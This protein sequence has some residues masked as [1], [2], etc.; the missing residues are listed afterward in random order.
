MLYLN[1]DLCLIPPAIL[2]K[3]S[4]ATNHETA[5]DNLQPAMPSSQEI[6]E[7][8]NDS[9]LD[10][11][12]YNLRIDDLAMHYGL[13]DGTAR[14][15][16]DALLNE[17]RVIAEIGGVSEEDVVIDFG[18]GYGSSAVWLAQHVGCRVT[19]ITLSQEQVDGAR[20][21]ARKRRVDDLLEFLVMDFHS[22]DLPSGS[23]DVVIAIE[24]MAHSPTKE[25][26]LAEAYRLLKPTGRIV[27]ADGFFRKPRAALTAVD[28]RIAS[29]CFEGVHVPILPERP[30]FERWLSDAGF[31]DIR[32]YDKT[33]GILPTGKRVHWLG[34]ILMPLARLFA[35]LGFDFLKPAHM[36]A[37]IDQYYA[38]RDGI[39]TYGIYFGRKPG[40]AT[41]SSTALSKR[42][43]FDKET[44]GHDEP[45]VGL[46]YSVCFNQYAVLC[47]RVGDTLYRHDN[48]ELVRHERCPMEIHT[49]ELD[50]MADL[51]PK[52]ESLLRQPD[53]GSE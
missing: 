26:V 13:W 41:G 52:C 25:R 8:Y 44:I 51:V 5:A 4:V 49:E 3:L 16:R 1:K 9:K 31:R 34:R 38:F 47:R 32:W 15:H 39:G 30:E 35:L 45:S 27:I 42:F 40:H 28:R 21:L 12:I 37:F 43:V 10:Y 18:C 6:V 7:Y 24:A 11:Q 46:Q 14:S 33:A 50:K 48:I 2:A 23:F 20:R 19:G 36:R 29:A 17:N 53:S 22:T